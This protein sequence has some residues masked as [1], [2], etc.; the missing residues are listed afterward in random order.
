MGFWNTSEGEDLK[1]ATGSFDAG[2]GGIKIGR[3]H[4]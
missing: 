3:A 2:G 1:Q 4:V